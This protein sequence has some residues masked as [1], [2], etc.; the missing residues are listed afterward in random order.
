MVTFRIDF[1]SY[2][3]F[4]P[5]C[6]RRQI[7]IDNA[8]RGER[9]GGALGLHPGWEFERRASYYQIWP[10]IWGWGLKNSNWRAFQKGMNIHMMFHV[11]SEFFNNLPYFVG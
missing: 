2:G 5:S 11:Q 6:K 9:G 3:Y 10:E 7:V 1:Y 4:K 8:C